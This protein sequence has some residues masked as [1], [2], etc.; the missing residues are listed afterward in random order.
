MILRA[1]PAALAALATLAALAVS[2]L[3][4]P[5][6][7]ESAGG[8]AVTYLDPVPA[9]W[10]PRATYTIGFWLLQHGT[11][12][13]VGRDLG[14]VALRFDDGE[15]TVLEFDAVELREPGH[16]AAAVALPGRTWRVE[17]LQGWFM[18]YEIGTLTVPG[19]LKIEP[20]P[21]EFRRSIE[22]QEPQDYWGEVRPPGFP[23]LAHKVPLPPRP[24]TTPAA[25]AVPSAASSGPTTA[26]VAEPEESWWRPPYAVAAG[27]L[28]G[29]LALL[30]LR[31]SRRLRGQ[32]HAAFS[33]PPG[34]TGRP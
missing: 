17:A 20:I 1:A 15:G 22:N 29:A 5:A 2:A 14:R 13:Y 6:R 9:K 33:R 24:S 31:R 32:G 11:H 34:G 12:P 7:A 8:W 25:A 27:V 10:E 19:S 18:P 28:I 3:A 16:Y 23:R 30:A 4:A 26:V 21:E